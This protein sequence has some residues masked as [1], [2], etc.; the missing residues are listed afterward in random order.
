MDCTTW[1]IISLPIHSWHTGMAAETSLS[2][3][4]A[5]V[6]PGLVFQTIRS[7]GGT[8]RSARMRSR[9]VA[10]ASVFGAWGFKLDLNLDD[11]LPTNKWGPRG[12]IAGGSTLSQA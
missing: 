8:F 2:A 3:T 4:V 11:G 6:I 10:G 5:L 9:Q 12:R 1:S 7:K